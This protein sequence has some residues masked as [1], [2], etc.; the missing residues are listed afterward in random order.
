MALTDAQIRNLTDSGKYSDGFGL[1]LELTK[2]GGKFWRMK[3]R[4]GGKEKKL[5]C[6]AYPDTSLKAA[7]E[8]AS[9]ARK[10]LHV[11]AD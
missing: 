2:A 5:A 11:D 6:G 10:T 8:K 7:R 9:E 3:Y 4:F 1:Y